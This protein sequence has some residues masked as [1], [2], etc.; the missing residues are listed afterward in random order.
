MITKSE[1]AELLTPFG[2]KAY[3]REGI[4]EIVAGEQVQEPPLCSK[5]AQKSTERE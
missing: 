1:L 3:S 5:K 4:L 2:Q